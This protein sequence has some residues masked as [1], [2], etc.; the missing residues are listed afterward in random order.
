M[1]KLSYRIGE[2]I[3]KAYA[4]LH[5]KTWNQYKTYAEVEKCSKVIR[6]KLHDPICDRVHA[7]F[8]GVYRKL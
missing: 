3:D 2:T 7:I 1:T 4:F 8:H 5:N 6:G